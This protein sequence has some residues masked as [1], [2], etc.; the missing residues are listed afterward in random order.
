M[1]R[2]IVPLLID[3]TLCHSGWRHA[4]V[5]L[6]WCEFPHPGSRPL[7]ITSRTRFLI[8][9][10][11]VCHLLVA[12]GIVT[13]QLLSTAPAG[14]QTSPSPAP[15]T[16]T[17]QEVTIRALQ[18]RKT[19]SCSSCAA[20]RKIHYGSYVLY[21]D[22]VHYN[23][24]TGDTVA[25]G[26]VVLDGGPNDE[27]VEASRTYN[28]RAETGRFEH[29]KGTTG[30]QLQGKRL[31][32]T[33][34]NPFAF[35]ARWWRRPRP[36]TTWSMTAPSRPANFRVPSG[37]SMPARWWWRSVETPASTTARSASREFRFSIFPSP[38]TPWGVCR[39]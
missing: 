23:S 16:V 20:S 33:S 12:R 3:V 1:I 6:S 5:T 8:T 19:A 24:D 38:P 35:T 39:R 14:T 37:C 4:N 18:E 7:A 21:A 27:Q 30:L 29:V 9:A 17:E 10:A 34:P 15:S 26:H 22:A 13:S 36:I 32:L 28:I 25:D 31:I 11:L 2:Q